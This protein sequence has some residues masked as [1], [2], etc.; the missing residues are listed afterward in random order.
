MLRLRSRCGSDGS[1]AVTLTLDPEVDV[2]VA[3][4]QIQ[5]S[6][7]RVLAQLGRES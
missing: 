6:I 3:Q 7:D 5:E 2:N 4:A 1:C